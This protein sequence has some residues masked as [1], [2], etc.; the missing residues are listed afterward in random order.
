MSR[1]MMWAFFWV[2]VIGYST[3]YWYP[4]APPWY[5]AEHGFGP[6]NLTTPANAA[7]CVRF[8]QLLGTQ[9]FSQWYGRS[10]D[11]FGA[12]PSL[13]VAY[14]FQAVYYSFKFGRAKVFA[15]LFFLIMC[16]SA[17]YL[18]HHYVLDVLLGVVYAIVVTWVVDFFYSKQIQ[19]QPT[20]ARKKNRDFSELDARL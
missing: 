3:Y 1:Q 16:F 18:N 20:Y 5:V 9:F 13:H 10:A 15:A 11:V 12:I 8:D 4:A 14:P 19:F 7:G 2:N 17:V 6:A